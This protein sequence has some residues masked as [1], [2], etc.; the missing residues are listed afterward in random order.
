MVAFPQSRSKIDVFSPKLMGPLWLPWQIKCSEGGALWPS[1]LVEEI[2]CAFCC[3]FW[4]TGLGALRYV[5]QELSLA[6]LSCR[7]E[8]PG[9][10]RGISMQR[11]TKCPE[12]KAFSMSQPQPVFHCYPMGTL[13]RTGLPESHESPNLWAK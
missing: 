8:V 2:L 4:D 5:H 11:G 9:R 12:W 6:T 10:R 1:S 7:P 3:F 13:S